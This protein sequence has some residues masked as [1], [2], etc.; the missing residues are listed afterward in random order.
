MASESIL[1]TRACLQAYVVSVV[2]TVALTTDTN[3]PRCISPL[4][5]ERVFLTFLHFTDA[6]FSGVLAWVTVNFLT[7]EM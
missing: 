3:H 4:D 5:V 1:F 7:G 2:K 6:L